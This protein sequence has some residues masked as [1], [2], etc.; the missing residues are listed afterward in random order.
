MYKTFELFDKPSIKL[1]V[2]CCNTHRLQTGS[3][4]DS[5]SVDSTLSVPS[6]TADKENL[7]G[8]NPA[9]KIDRRFPEKVLLFF[10]SAIIPNVNLAIPQQEQ[11]QAPQQGPL[12]AT[13]WTDV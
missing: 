7:K 5:E 9:S 12:Q 4:T 2:V 10:L 8:R 1:V 11:E 3:L 13:E 6:L